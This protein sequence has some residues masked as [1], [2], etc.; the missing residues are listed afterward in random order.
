[1]TN[2][3]LPCARKKNNQKPTTEIVEIEKHILNQYKHIFCDPSNILNIAELILEQRE[4]ELSFEG[5]NYFCFTKDGMMMAILNV[6]EVF[7]DIYHVE[8]IQ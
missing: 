6:A 1:M 5:N 2:P 4:T 7:R 3:V 8:L